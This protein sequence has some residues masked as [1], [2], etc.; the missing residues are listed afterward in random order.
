MPPSRASDVPDALAERDRRRG[1]FE[2]PAGGLLDRLIRRDR[3]SDSTTLRPRAGITSCSLSAARA[4]AIAVPML[5]ERRLVGA[6]VIYRQEVRPF[7]DKQ[8]ELVH[9]FRRPGRH[10]DREHAPAQRAAPAH[11]RSHRGAGAADRDL[12]GAQGHLQLAGRAQAGVPGHAG[13]R[14]AHLRGQ[15]RRADLD[16]R[17]AMSRAAAHATARLPHLSANRRETAIRP[18]R[19]TRT[20]RGH[21]TRQALS[22]FDDSRMTR[23]RRHT[24]R[25]NGSAAPAPFWRVPM[26][27]DNELIGVY[28]HL[29]PEV[30]PFTDKQIELVR[31]SPRR[32]SSRSRTR[33]CSTSCASAPTNSP[34]RW[35]SRPRPRR[36]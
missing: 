7:T 1:T 32:P 4:A 18:G 36:C 6:I 31:T 26:L 9:Q 3:S 35:S 25:A 17:M 2:P 13:E 23:R 29:S 21:A 5:K 14:G 34:K 19:D 20:A 10:R 30:R 8:I 11:R 12:G 28:H 33:A 27:K 16:R 24:R 22:I 15:V